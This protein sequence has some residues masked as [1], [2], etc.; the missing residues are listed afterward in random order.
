MT[1]A[2]RQAKLFS[3]PQQ[4]LIV[5]KRIGNR[6]A[7]AI[8]QL[9]ERRCERLK[10]ARPWLQGDIRPA[11]AARQRAAL[12][13]RQQPRQNG[14][15]FAAARW[16]QHHQQPLVAHLLDHGG[17]QR[18]A[19]KEE[20]GV[21]LLVGVQAD[22]GNVWRTRRAGA[23][24]SARQGDKRGALFGGDGQVIR[25]QIGD[26][27]GR[28]QPAGLNFADGLG[29]TANPPS[30]FVLCQIERFTALLH[31]AAERDCYVHV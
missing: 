27:A 23:R 18:L 12:E 30:K 6:I 14:A 22:I 26:L 21:L 20:R 2:R 3:H 7:G 1:L 29:R 15:T 10:R 17:N 9:I 8:V 16:T 31:P 25:Q 24:A 13:G 5:G 19:P 11:L 28:A 4:R